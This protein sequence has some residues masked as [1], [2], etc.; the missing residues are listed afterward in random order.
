[1]KTNKNV[2]RDPDDNADKLAKS[3]FLDSLDRKKVSSMG[4]PPPPS[5]S[6]KV[7]IPD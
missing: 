3:L 1:M 2:G 5:Q 4:T 7:A 6:F